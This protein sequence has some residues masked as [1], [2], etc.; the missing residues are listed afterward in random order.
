MK[1]NWL[2]VKEFIK[3]RKK[4]ITITMEVPDGDYER[5]RKAVPGYEK[6]GEM[7]NG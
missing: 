1:P 4:D 5:Y 6:D 2:P 7:Q 3:S